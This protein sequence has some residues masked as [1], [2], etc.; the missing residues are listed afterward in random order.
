[1]KFAARDGSAARTLAHTASPAPG[2]AGSYA[3]PGWYAQGV[4][5]TSRSTPAMVRPSGADN[6]QRAPRPRSSVPSTVSYLRGQEIFAPGRGQGFVYIVRSGCVRLYKVLPDGRSINL[7]LLGPNTVFT[8]ED[9]SD[10]IASG[11]IAEALVDSTLSVV[12]ADQLAAIIADS[13]ELAAAMVTGMGR[14]LT[15]LQTLV[16][17][18]LVRDTAVRL[19]TTLLGLAGRFGRPTA[20][21]MTAIALPLTHQGLASMIG[22]NRVTVTR[23]LL[24]LQ[25]RGAVRSLGRNAVAVNPDMLREYAHA[26]SEHERRTA[27]QRNGRTRSQQDGRNG[28]ICATGGGRGRRAG[29]GTHLHHRWHRV[30]RFEHPRGAR[31]PPSAAARPRSKRATPISKRRGSSCR[32]GDVTKPETLRGAMDGCDAVIHL[33]AIIAEEGGATFDGVIRQG[34]INVVD[35]AK[36]VGLRPLHP[37]ERDGRGQQPRLPLHAGQV[38]GRASGQGIGHGV[39]DFSAF[40]HLRPR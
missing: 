13:P 29:D 27:W 4:A 15:E 22:S 30:R 5:G 36:R 12:E 9:G 31:R 28:R 16:E 37:H 32:E 11:A 40:G 26:A 19:A 18:L 8:Q 7:G 33:V 24:E 3:A 1:M 39:D 23:K 6:G 10:G 14:R 38:A 20:D 25:D 21:G 17:H 34:T 35:E 2:R